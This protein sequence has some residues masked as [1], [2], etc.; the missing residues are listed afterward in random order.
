M[1]LVRTNQL[2]PIYRIAA[3][4]ATIFHAEYPGRS[5]VAP[6]SM[7]A[8]GD[9]SFAMVAHIAFAS[10]ASS[11]S[12]KVLD[13]AHQHSAAEGVSYSHHVLKSRLAHRRIPCGQE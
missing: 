6:S 13:I 5:A 12:G 11:S 3:S 8:V 1:R 7:V 10:L 4:V 9:H 2:S